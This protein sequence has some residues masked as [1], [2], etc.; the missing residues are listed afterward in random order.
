MRSLQKKSAVVVVLTVLLTSTCS[1]QTNHQSV[2][3]SLRVD[4]QSV[5]E[6]WEVASSVKHLSFV[7]GFDGQFTGLE[8]L[9]SLES[10]YV[11]YWTESDWDSLPE[12]ERVKYLTVTFSEVPSLSVL[13]RFP[14][15]RQLIM[16]NCEV[17]DQFPNL[18]LLRLPNLE[19]ADF[20]GSTLGTVPTFLSTDESPLCYLNLAL[21]AVTSISDSE[22]AQLQMIPFVSLA[23]NPIWNQQRMP[24][25][26]GPIVK[27]VPQELRKRYD[28]L[29]AYAPEER[30]GFSGD[31]SRMP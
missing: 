9:E 24:E 18:D 7:G 10:I 16:T 19:Y 14:N 21:T 4:G 23:D 1:S 20:F 2:T 6:T 8:Q 13:Y 27:D 5:T 29:E 12:L 11:S 26:F 3:I 30:G 31:R 25:Q 15:M 22:Q 28:L 17:L